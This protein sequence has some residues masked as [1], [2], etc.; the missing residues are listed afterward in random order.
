[1]PARTRAALL[2]PLG[3][4]EGARWPHSH[5]CSWCWGTSVSPPP[6]SLAPRG[7]PAAMASEG[8]VPRGRRWSLKA[9]E[10]Q[11]R[12]SLNHPSRHILLCKESP[13][14]R[15]RGDGPHLWEEEEG[16]SPRAE[17]PG[18]RDAGNLWP[19]FAV[20]E[21][22]S[23]GFCQVLTG[24]GVRGASSK[25]IGYRAKNYPVELPL[26]TPYVATACRAP[27]SAPTLQGAPGPLSGRVPEAGQ[28]RGEACPGIPGFAG[29]GETPD[30]SW[31][32]R[33]SHL[34]RRLHSVCL[35]SL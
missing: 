25:V 15:G 13:M 22:A 8:S 7:Q 4:P 34:L 6:G 18:Y 2:V 35:V 1:M 5:G 28:V 9:L 24:V 10:V 3:S 30:P 31:E 32:W 12:N 26:K 33:G 14:A 16:A 29:L 17:G 23:L 27:G 19:Y 21:Y 11:P 20:T